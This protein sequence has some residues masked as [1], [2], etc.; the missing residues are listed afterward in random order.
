[1]HKTHFTFSSFHFQH[2]FYPFFVTLWLFKQDKLI[3]NSESKSM[4]LMFL[5]HTIIIILHNTAVTEQNKQMGSTSTEF[6][7]IVT[8]WHDSLSKY[9]Q[10]LQ[11]VKFRKMSVL[12]SARPIWPL[13]CIWRDIL[14]IIY[15]I[16]P[17]EGETLQKSQCDHYACPFFWHQISWCGM[18]HVTGGQIFLSSTWI[19]HR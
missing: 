3:S 10:H 11:Q 16:W 4:F 14:I 18:A 6:F 2:Y 17:I 8:V 9:F 13:Q 1:M 15:G 7:E 12:P 19:Y 5:H